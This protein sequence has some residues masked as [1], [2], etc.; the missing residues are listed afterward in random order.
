MFKLKEPLIKKNTLYFDK[1]ILEQKKNYINIPKSA[2][3]SAKTDI[4]LITYRLIEANKEDMLLQRYKN[5]L[6]EKSPSNTISRNS[7]T[8][9]TQSSNW[10]T[11]MKKILDVLELNKTK[12]YRATNKNL[13]TNL[14]D[15]IANGIL[16]SS[17][18][19]SDSASRRNSLFRKQNTSSAMSNDGGGNGGRRQSIVSSVG[20]LSKPA[21]RRPSVTV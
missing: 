3:N 14:F 12:S 13:S 9:T 4:Q 21:S 5:S 1:D 2:R 11:N 8:T 18:L 16:K 19:H 6:T 17:Q 10:K 15:Q 7:T 20:K